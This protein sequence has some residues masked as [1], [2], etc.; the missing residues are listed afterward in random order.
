VVTRKLSS[1]AAT[2]AQR[3]SLQQPLA[4]TAPLLRQIDELKSDLAASD[5]ARRA[6]ARA[7]DA[8]TL[9]LQQA[10]IECNVYRTRYAYTCS[11]QQLC[12]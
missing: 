8:A 7:A 1:T 10:R 9:D 4:N 6:A 5:A 2:A 3:P 11:I 12:V